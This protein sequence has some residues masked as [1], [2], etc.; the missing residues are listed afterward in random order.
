MALFR[1][2]SKRTGGDAGDV[3]GLQPSATGETAAD[4]PSP[5]EPADAG[6][7]GLDRFGPFDSGDV[8]S[9]EGFVDLGAILLPAIEGLLLTMEVDESNGDVTAVRVHLADSLLQL[10]AFAA[11]RSQGLWEEIRAD[12]AE[13]LGPAG[14]SY[15]E[16]EGPYGTELLARVPAAGTDGRTITNHMRFLGVDGPRWF[17]RAV[18]SGPA[19]TDEAVAQPFVDLLRLVVVVRGSEPM[20]PRELLP[21]RMPE[22]L[23]AP[24]IEDDEGPGSTD[25]LRPFERGPEITEIR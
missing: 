3:D 15:E 9:T 25:D 14:G 16:P 7:E 19:A 8:P 12:I 11:P 13:S 1:R 20:G 22:E 18:I 4:V 23:P 21:L 6:E 24:P 17:L 5:Q 10:Q 2:K